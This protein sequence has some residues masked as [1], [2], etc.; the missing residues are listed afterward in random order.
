MLMGVSLSL[1]HDI[2]NKQKAYQS[3]TNNKYIRDFEAT[4][5]VR[6]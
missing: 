2:L 5:Y 1:L 6:N 3:V 4:V